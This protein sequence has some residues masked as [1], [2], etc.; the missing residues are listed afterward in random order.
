[1]QSLVG[2]WL[3]NALGCSFL[4]VS[5]ALGQ[6]SLP[7]LQ[8]ELI[9]KPLYLKGL[10]KANKLKFNSAG[11][12]TTPGGDTPFTLAG[13]DVGD[14]EFEGNGLVITGSRM[15]I[16]FL[17]GLPRM[18][19][20]Q[21][22]RI[23]IQG[24]PATDFGPALAKIFA[25][26]LAGLV[27]EMPSFWQPIARK[28]FL[29]PPQPAPPGMSLDPAPQDE[30]PDTLPVLLTNVPAVPNDSARALGYRGVTRIRLQVNP[31]GTPTNLRIVTACGMGL[32]EQAVA[33]VSQYRYKPA[34]LDGKPVQAE[35]VAVV[36]FQGY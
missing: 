17:P 22:V 12:T 14:V 33:A 10:W 21:D 5:S 24:T 16:E 26:D 6:S 31:D 3:L 27:P 30:Q 7:V 35:V 9:H 28:Y 1:M 18:A 19:L 15:G 29:T 11:V 23:E 25:K 13:I 4:L 36:K 32:D 20:H 34:T 2:K 8:S